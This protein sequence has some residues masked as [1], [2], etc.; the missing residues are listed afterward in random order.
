MATSASN[1]SGT[2]E[3]LVTRENRI[4]HASAG[5]SFSLP[6]VPDLGDLRPPL[7]SGSCQPG[8]TTTNCAEE[9]NVN[10]ALR[11]DR[12]SSGFHYRDPPRLS[13]VGVD[14]CRSR[15]SQIAA[16]E[17]DPIA[18]NSLR[19]LSRNLQSTE[20]PSSNTVR[21]TIL[22]ETSRHDRFQPTADPAKTDVHFAGYLQEDP[23]PQLDGRSILF[24]MPT[25]I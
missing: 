24:C 17:P 7:W 19:R 5:E 2:S 16:S 12:R 3:S 20:P 22:L 23:G 14:N 15:R 10:V 13:K 6:H 8:S 4:E 25:A 9:D 11:G 18:M 21:E 1:R